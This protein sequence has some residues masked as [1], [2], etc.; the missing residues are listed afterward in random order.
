VKQLI[1]VPPQ[2]EIE[3][4]WNLTLARFYEWL[5]DDLFHFMW[6]VLLVLVIATTYL[7]WKKVNKSRLSEI[8]LYTFLIIIFIIVL[9]E[10]GEEL[11]LWYYTV[12][13]I[14]FFPPITAVDISSMPLIYMLIYQRFGSWK[15][16]V[17]ASIVMSAVFCFVFEPIFVWVG[18]YKMI[19]WKSY[20]G[21]PI[22][23]F[24]A[25]ASKFIVNLI[26]GISSKR[27]LHHSPDQ[28]QRP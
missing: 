9:D 2:P 25:I 21:F 24:I 18:V 8:A 4:Q 6:W 1:T 16:F 3:E 15:S 23:I 10:L 17:V 7:W 22:Y 12:D 5:H 19:S 26:C 20:Y 11:S 28:L 27:K 13:L 14:C